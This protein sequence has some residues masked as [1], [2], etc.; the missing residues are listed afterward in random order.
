VNL[1]ALSKNGPQP[2]P[3]IVWFGEDVPLIPKAVEIVSRCEALIIVGTSMQVYPAAGLLNYAPVD[4]PIFFVD[5]NPAVASGGRIQVIAQ[6][7][8]KGI[9]TVVDLLN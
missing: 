8:T 9:P 2:R 5:P 1:G 3:H 4:T 6:T 7:A